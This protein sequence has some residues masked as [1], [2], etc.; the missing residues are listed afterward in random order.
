MSAYWKITPAFTGA[1]WAFLRIM[2]LCHGMWS[3][4]QGKKEAVPLLF[5]PVPP[6]YTLNGFTDESPCLHILIAY[7]R[8][9]CMC[10]ASPFSSTAHPWD[11]Q[12]LCLN[13]ST[14]LHRWL[15]FL[16]VLNTAKICPKEMTSDIMKRN[17]SIW[18]LIQ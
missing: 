13:L 18:C 1:S 12:E 3:L 4:L 16:K 14:E 15:I 6:I 8:Y 9:S 5:P 17:M 2:D 7:V 11:T 10:S